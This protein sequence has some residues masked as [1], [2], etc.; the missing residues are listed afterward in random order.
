MMMA[1]HSAR[2]LSY[3]AGVALMLL[4]SGVLAALL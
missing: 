4:A 3:L 2:R 1:F